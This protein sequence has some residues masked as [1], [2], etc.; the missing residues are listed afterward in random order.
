VS[1]A[2]VS[3]PLKTERAAAG[4]VTNQA[5]EDP[6]PDL[7]NQQPGLDAELAKFSPDSGIDS[8]I[9]TLLSLWGIDYGAAAG[10]ACGQAEAQG[11]G[12]SVQHGSWNEIRQLDRPVLL[13]LTDSQGK[14]HRPVLVGLDNEVAKLSLGDQQVTFPVDEVADLWF[15]QFLL[16]WRPAGRTPVVISPGMQNDNVRWLRRSL[17]A[18]DSSYQPQFADS[19]YFDNGLQQQLMAFQRQHRLKT[20]GLAGQKTQI[21]INSLLAVDG[22][23]RLSIVQ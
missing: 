18:L 6:L 13:T 1:D 14:T 17:A 21:I 23:P 11:L 9:T 20:D 19:D 22:T 7:T 2:V 10:P 4:P 12:C 5:G 15:G 8:G 16:I 3:G